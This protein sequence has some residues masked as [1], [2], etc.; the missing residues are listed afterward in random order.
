[1]RAYWNNSR[2]S[3]A[4]ASTVALVAVLHE[5]LRSREEEPQFASLYEREIVVLDYLMTAKQLIDIFQNGEN[6]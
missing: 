3:F 5:L 2:C 1:M 6:Y 4:T